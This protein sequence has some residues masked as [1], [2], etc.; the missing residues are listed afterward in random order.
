MAYDEGWVCLRVRGEIGLW[1]EVD[2]RVRSHEPA[3][4][5]TGELAWL[6]D[7]LKPQNLPVKATSFSLVTWRHRQLDMVDADDIDRWRVHAN[8][9]TVV[10][11]LHV[12]VVGVDER[13]MARFVNDEQTEHR[14]STV[15]VADDDPNGFDPFPLDER[16]ITCEEGRG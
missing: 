8:V 1:R 14:L 4:A 9:V 13:C 6:G 5:S 11:A 3:A 10:G 7:F 16:G 15:A 2:R 12:H